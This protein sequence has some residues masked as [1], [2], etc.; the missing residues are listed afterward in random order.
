MIP[1]PS[2]RR[3]AARVAA[4]LR[5]W[6]PAVLAERARRLLAAGAAGRARPLLREAVRRAPSW[7]E[8]HYLLGRCAAA[9][10]ERDAEEAAYLRALQLE[11]GHEEAERAL[12]RLRAW[13]Y[14]P[15]MAGWRFFHAGRHEEAIAAFAA[16]FDE[17][18]DRVAPALRGE[19][20]S[21]IGWARYERGEWA[22]AEQAFADAVDGGAAPDHAWKGRGMSLYRLE[23]H[24]EAAAA[25]HA[26][27]ER[28]PAMHDARAFLGWCAYSLGRAEEASA[29][30]Q[31]ALD[32]NPLQADAWW[33]MAWS[34]RR[35]GQPA[36]ARASFRRAIQLG[37][38][39]PSVDPA[40]A[41]FT[42]DAE[43]RELQLPLGQALLDAGRPARAL[44]VFEAGLGGAPRA[45]VAAA[46]ARALL[47]L[48]RPAEA[49]SALAALEEHEMDAE[50]PTAPGLSP[51]HLKAQAAAALGHG[52]EAR[53]LLREVLRRRPDA[54]LA[55]VDLA[56]QL[57]AVGELDEAES[58]LRA[59]LAAQ[60]DHRPARRGLAALAT[61]RRAPLFDALEALVLGRPGE[62]EAALQK[63]PPPAGR[64]RRRV[65]FLR[66]RAAEVRA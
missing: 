43:F 38:D 51:R 31:A 17:P 16:A 40:L 5:L 7:A 55:R 48:G 52:E 34:A 20:R 58:H 61:R 36:E 12:L 53:A 41:L 9:S 14:E 21:G 57:L 4:R 19:V 23:R 50:L 39:H 27:L 18:E 63:L 54:H 37:P 56:H 6:R 59:A 25:L 47:A 30:F 32:G 62:V 15:V 13:R 45:K 35:R 28:N 1:A 65:A 60:P 8:P 11:P 33:G 22:A 64:D 42:H 29:H 24:A 2:S 44:T 26:A 66:S 10:G 49:E 46:R 3:W